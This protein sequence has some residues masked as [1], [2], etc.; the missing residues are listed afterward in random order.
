MKGLAVSVIK[1]VQQSVWWLTAVI[2]AL[3]RVESFRAAW[4]ETFKTNIQKINK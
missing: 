3:Q 2:P 4:V 1:N